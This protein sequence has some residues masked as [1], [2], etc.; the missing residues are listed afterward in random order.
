MPISDYD[1]IPCGIRFEEIFLSGQTV[2]DE[3]PCPRCEQPAP[4]VMVARFSIVGPIFADMEKYEAA[5]LKPVERAR[6]IRFRSGKDIERWER[7]RGLSRIDQNTARASEIRGDALDEVSTRNRIIK[8]D[9]ASGEADWIAKQE[10]M[11]AAN[12][13]DMQ[14]VRWKELSDAAESSARNGN[15]PISDAGTG[16]SSGPSSGSA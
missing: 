6:G 14:Y 11:E 8:S 1:C 13:T 7:E 15:T 3:W 5:L 10:I 9:G 2:P 16:Q 12:M 4:R